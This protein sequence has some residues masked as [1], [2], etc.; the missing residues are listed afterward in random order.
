MAQT[1]TLIVGD[2]HF[3]YHDPRAVEAAL[4]RARQ[5]KP[6]TIVVNGDLLDCEDLSRFP[7]DPRTTAKFEAELELAKDFLRRLPPCRLLLTMGNHEERIQRLLWKQAPALSGLACLRVPALLGLSSGHYRDR[8]FRIGRLLVQHGEA[9]G[10]TAAR[11]SLDKWPG[12]NVVQGHSHRLSQIWRRTHLGTFSS[13]EGGCL[14]DLSPSYCHLPDW[15]Q[16]W[17]V[18]DGK[19][20]H[21]ER[22]ENGKIL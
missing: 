10:T 1:R 18:W 7:K 12:L 21:L 11:K 15:Q 9:Y 4:R 17:T 14:C 8:P 3:P 20:L 19:E 16:G 13:V 22:V 6:Q 2:L 5:L